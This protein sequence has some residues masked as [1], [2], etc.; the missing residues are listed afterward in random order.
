MTNSDTIDELATTAVHVSITSF[1]S[2]SLTTRATLRGV[3]FSSATTHTSFVASMHTTPVI[4]TVVSI[5]KR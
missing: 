5:K 4:P 1:G 3:K 2:P